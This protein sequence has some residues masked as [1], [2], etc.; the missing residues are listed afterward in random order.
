[1]MAMG[2][3]LKKVISGLVSLEGEEGLARIKL[4]ALRALVHYHG[5]IWLSELVQELQ[6]KSAADGSPKPEEKLLKK[7]L[8]DLERDGV[9]RIKKAFRA[10]L[11][12]RDG[13]KDELISLVDL[14]LTYA[15]LVKNKAL[16]SFW[17]K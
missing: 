15:T 11:Q 10:T 3:D 14:Q 9:V 5:A 7:G 17:F 6:L 8:Q 12:S 2:T 1:M 13:V 4:D 16:G